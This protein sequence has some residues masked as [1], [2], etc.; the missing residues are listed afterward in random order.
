[1][2][3][4]FFAMKMEI[5]SQVKEVKHKAYDISIAL[6]LRAS[7]LPG[8]SAMTMD[9]VITAWLNHSLRREEV[10]SAMLETL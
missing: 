10:W 4:D 2:E 8:R 9:D 5:L 7:T 1:M 6:R 3:D